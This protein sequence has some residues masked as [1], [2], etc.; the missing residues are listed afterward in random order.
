[1]STVDVFAVIRWWAVLLVL[2]T[3]VFP[4][5]YTLFKK[6]PDRGYAFTKMVGLLLVTYLFWILNSLRFLDNNAGSIVFALAV[7]LG[8][9]IWMYRRAIVGN[10]EAQPMLEW[11]RDNKRIVIITELLFL[12]VFV[13]WVWVRAQ[14]PAIVNTEK[15]MDFAFLNA[16]SR[17]AT[18]PPLDPWLSGFA[19]SYYYFGYVMTSVITRLAAVPTAIGFNLGIAWLVAGTAVASFGLVFNLVSLQRAREGFSRAAMLLGIVAAFAIPIAG[20]QEIVLEMMYANR[21]GSEEFWTWLD[22]RDLNIPQPEEDFEPRYESSVWWWWRSSRPINEYSL[23]GQQVEGLE[24]I[25]E[26]PS[27]SFMLGDMHPH[28]MALPFALLSLA[29][30]LAWWIDSQSRDISAWEPDK[31]TLDSVRKMVAGLLPEWPLWLFTALVL[32]G[33]SFLNTWDVLIHLFVILG[34]FLLGQWQR[35]GWDMQ[36]LWQTVVTAVTLIIPAILL[37]LPFYFGFRSQAG[38]PY[39]LPMLF[40]PT[41]LPQFL[42]IFGM[43]L[44]VLTILMFSLGVKQ[45]FRQWKVGLITAVSIIGGLLLLMLLLGWIIA[46]SPDGAGQVINV[47]NELGIS[48][49]GRPDGAVTLGW[50]FSTILRIFPAIIN[51]K[52][53][54]VGVTLLL[55]AFL[56]LAVMTWAEIFNAKAQRREE[57]KEEGEEGKEEG[58]R[59]KEEIGESITPSSLH[60]ILL[61]TVTASLLTLG[62]EFVYLRDNFGYRLNTIFKFYYQAWVM[63]G[64][65]AIVGIDYLWRTYTTIPERIIPA[66]STLGYTATLLMAM[67]FPYHAINSRAIEYRGPVDAS[68]R[69]PATLDGLARLRTYNQDEYDAI[70]WLQ[71]NTT[72]TPVVLEATGGA[73]S[74]YGRV[75]ANTGLPTVL[76]WANH[77]FQWRGSDTPEPGAREPI[78]R[79]IYSRPF[80]ENT[81]FFLNQYD[82]EYIYVGGLEVSSYG[83]EGVLLGK[84]KFDAQLEVAY[85][86]NSVTI[87][88]WHPT[89][90]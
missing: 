52:L 20:N 71:N 85:Q 80:W 37:Y 1:M 12:A 23:A 47:A 9:S 5:T 45:R 50:G 70:L 89:E 21:I 82:V 2:G 77:E 87:Y 11:L 25:V 31:W 6:L 14:N 74:D 76:G 44:W 53:E 83:V 30:A 66:I 67:M 69:L 56:S 38:A 4:L 46:S 68:E 28:V 57:E 36:I 8:I 88:R 79:E 42:I 54:F 3:A 73:Y 60:F 7:V 55:T 65:A 63:F 75:A 84:E 72:G 40:R 48:L 90:N 34:A 35:R 15:P 58:R 29:V 33:L 61:L 78:I 41:R 59:K 43:P 24:P 62:P 51:A 16:A 64:I 10:A 32:G 49:P 81:G 27:F 13:L 17:S 86:N 39:L 18:Y 22:V 19:I 26:V